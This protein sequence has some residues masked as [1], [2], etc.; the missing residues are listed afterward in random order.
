ML[1]SDANNHTHFAYDAWGRVVQTTFPS[2]LAETYAYDAVGNL[3]SKTD[4]KNQTIQ[5]VCCWARHGAATCSCASSKKHETAT[6]CAGRRLSK[7][8]RVRRSAGDYLGDLL[9]IA[10]SLYFCGVRVE[11]CCET[12][13]PDVLPAGVERIVG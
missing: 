10:N 12:V 11:G 3:S 8:L 13:S 4:R 7:P 1:E 9:V 2:A 6:D 5:Y